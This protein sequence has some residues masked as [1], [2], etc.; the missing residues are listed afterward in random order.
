[1]QMDLPYVGRRCFMTSPM[2]RGNNARRWLRIC[3]RFTAPARSKKLNNGE[4]GT[5]P[6]RHQ[7]DG[8]LEPEALEAILYLFSAMPRLWGEA[9]LFDRI[10]PV[11]RL[12]K[13][14]AA[15]RLVFTGETADELPDT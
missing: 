8:A 10:L 11:G 1:M 15:G 2:H 6:I 4:N 3:S 14:R 7:P 12:C 13:R 5:E 9:A